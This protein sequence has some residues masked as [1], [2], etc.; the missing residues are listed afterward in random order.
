MLKTESV[1]EYEGAETYSSHPPRGEVVSYRQ[2]FEALAKQVLST[3]ATVVTTLPR[4][5]LQVVQPA[6]VPD[7]L[8]RPYVREFHT[9]DRW[10]WHALTHGKPATPSGH[11]FEQ[12]RLYRDFLVPNNY[13][14]MA[15]APLV[16]PVFRG[17]PG[18]LQVFRTAEQGAFSADDLHALTKAAHQF[19]QAMEHS[20]TSRRTG[21]CTRDLPWAHKASAKQFVFDA[22][23]KV[24]LN[25]HA[26]KDLDERLR[27]QLSRQIRHRLAD[28]NGEAVVAERVLLPDASGDLWTFRVIVYRKYP[29][30]SHGPIAFVSLQPDC[31]DWGALRS[32]D[33]QADQEVAR[34]VPAL[35]FMQE[36]FH[37]GPT[38]NEIAKTVHL[39][40]FHFHR[41]FTELLGITPKHFLLECQIY[42]AKLQ[43]ATGEKELVD[44]AS[45]CGFAHQSH[46]TSRFK[47]ATGLTPTRWRKVLVKDTAA[48]TV[49]M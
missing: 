17:Y 13:R 48:A 36:E 28:T 39:S 11:D 15:V 49:H 3:E 2:N 47:Q 37:R 40:P 7:T 45:G 25:S 43:L 44:I 46:F 4:G 34:L 19:E 16:S 33:F 24:L 1:R 8:L 35:Q 22:E 21:T 30:L 20:H 26:L 32:T 12:S 5:G 10:T 23:G 6:K 29:A 31:C 42:E 14:H 41:R 27:D 18:A 38:L 9:E